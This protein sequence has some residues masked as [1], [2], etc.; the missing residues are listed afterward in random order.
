MAIILALCLFSADDLGSFPTKELR[1][2]ILGEPSAADRF[3]L[4][5]IWFVGHTP[6]PEQPKQVAMWWHYVGKAK[7]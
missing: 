1:D 3:A 7:S 4:L 5:P 6:E 2:K